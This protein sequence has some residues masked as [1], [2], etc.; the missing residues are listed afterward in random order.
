M[1]ID[2]YKNIF[3]R[4][5]PSEKV[6]YYQVYNASEGF[7][8][9][10]HQNDRDD[11]LLLVEHQIFYEFIPFEQ[12]L[13]KEYCNAIPLADVN[14]GE[15]YVIVITNGSGLWRYVLGDVV[16]FTGTTPHTIKIT[17]RTKYYIDVAGE[18]TPLKP[19]EEAIS[20]TAQQFQ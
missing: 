20:E 13:R 10:Q 12:Y 3:D 4:L 17:G 6:H 2:L 8:A 5:L 18:C 1:S 15:Q 9:T 16:E 7:F 11:M 14:V 19:I